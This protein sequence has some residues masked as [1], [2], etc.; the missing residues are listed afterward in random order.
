MAQPQQR[1][2]FVCLEGIENS[3]KTTQSTLLRDALIS[4]GIPARVVCFPDRTTTTG[5]LLDS[6]LKEKADLE[7]H[8]LHLLFSMNRWE[9]MDEMKKEL[10]SGTTLI[11]DR[12]AYSGI[13]Y[14]I[15]KGLDPAWCVGPDAGIVK[16]DL[17]VY[18]SLEV[19]QALKR[20]AEKPP[21]KHDKPV[22]LAGVKSCYDNFFSRGNCLKID[23]LLDKDTILAQIL[24]V[25]LEVI[26]KVK[27]TAITH[28]WV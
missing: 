20:G 2:A 3:G 23:A 5:R 7:P 8:A 1:G 9:A 6:V 24:T 25:C 11:V 28:L 19:D 13:S 17:N 27:T 16:P 15:A 4:R 14:S 18:L 26:S 10:L 22:I 21:E 12:Y